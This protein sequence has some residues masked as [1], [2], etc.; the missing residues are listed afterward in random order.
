MAETSET[1]GTREVFTPEKLV[2]CDRYW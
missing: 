1:K 2:W